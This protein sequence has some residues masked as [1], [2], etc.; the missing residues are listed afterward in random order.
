MSGG[1]D[2]EEAEKRPPLQCRVSRETQN[3]F[4]EWLDRIGQNQRGA[5]GYN[6][7][8]AMEEYMDKDRYA[9]IEERVDRIESVVAETNALVRSLLTAEKEKA[10][11][12][13][14]IPNGNT[15]A[16]RRQRENL[17]IKKLGEM[18]A[19]KKQRRF[20]R[21]KVA[22]AIRNG[23]GVSSEPTVEDYIDALI[24]RGLIEPAGSEYLITTAGLE[25]GG[26]ALSPQD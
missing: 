15:P 14:D 4:G 3:R 18:A 11:F 13:D 26:F 25:A 16:A 24:D 5:Y 17:A 8:R 19:E 21:P 12:L 2:S 1:D 10:V 6:V 23:A 22:G 20:S 9:S 7:E